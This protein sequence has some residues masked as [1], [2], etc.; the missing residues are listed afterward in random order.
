MDQLLCLSKLTISEMTM[1]IEDGNLLK[2][3]FIHCLNIAR[4][5]TYHILPQDRFENI[6]VAGFL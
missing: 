2:Q 3:S 4:P 1:L 5:V 6:F